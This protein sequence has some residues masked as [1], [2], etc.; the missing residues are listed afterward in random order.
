LLW[1]EA[2]RVGAALVGIAT[3]VR[4]AKADRRLRLGAP[5]CCLAI[6]CD[7]QGLLNHLRGASAGIHGDRG[8]HRFVG[9]REHRT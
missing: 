6:A 4:R 3:A 8:L 1:P 9:V 5:V 2:Q 7:N